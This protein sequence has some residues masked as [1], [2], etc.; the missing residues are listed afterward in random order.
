MTRVSFI[1]GPDLPVA[2]E[3]LERSIETWSRELGV[4]AS[5]TFARD[6]AALL[7]ALAPEALDDVDGIVVC[8]AGD[9]RTDELAQAAQRAGVPLAWVDLRSADGPP[10]PHHRPGAISIRGRGIAGYRWALGQLLQCIDCPP[11]TIAYGPD[12]RDQVADLRVPPGDGPH[13]VAVL[14]HGGFWRERWE[15]DTIEPL[16]IDLAHRGFASWNVEYRRVGPSGG[17]FATTSDDVAAAIDHLERLAED[18][19]L[20]LDRVVLI[21]HSAGGQLA[22]WAVHRR[23]VDRPERVM[24][25]L[26]VALAPV[27]DLAEAAHRSLGDT[28][29]P[30]VD[31]LGAGPDRDPA[32]YAAASPIETLPQ[33]VPQV[34]FQGRRDNTPDLIDLTHRYVLAARAAGDRIELVEHD[35]ADHFAPIVPTSAAWRAVLESMIPWF[36]EAAPAAGTA[37]TRPTAPGGTDPDVPTPREEPDGD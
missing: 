22:L 7:A 2:T 23:G 6:D 36:P 10:P 21:G 14:L 4:D 37:T 17:G 19:P 33:A 12:P 28:G 29:N 15:R 16:A 8:P 20:D 26:V 3:S 34:V 11:R 30:V 1:S 18:H 31:F 9:L 5:T 13:P 27:A 35:D 25:A 32:R 24:P